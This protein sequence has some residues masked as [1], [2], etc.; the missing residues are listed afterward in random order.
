MP[1]IDI[2]NEPCNDGVAIVIFGVTGDLARR[3][4]MPS[5]YENARNGRLPSPFYIL[6][7]ARRPW[8]HEKMRDVLREGVME[9]GRTKPVDEEIL[10]AILE[11][12]YYIEST[13][14]NPE[15]YTKL[16]ESLKRLGVQNTLFY[17]STP[18]GWYSTIVENIGE[19]QLESCTQGWRRI[20]VEKPFGRDLATAHELD[21]KLHS[22]FAEDQ[23][24][25]MDHYLGKETVQN[26][27]A[28]RFGNGIFEP[29]W[30]RKYVDHIQIT[31]AET[32]GVG[33]RAGYYDKSGVIRDVF[34]NHLLQL[35]SLTAM[36]AP[37]VFNAKAVRDEKVKVLKSIEQITGETALENTIRAQYVS[38][39]IDGERV[40]S[41]RDEP[42]VAPDSITETYV[43]AR[44]FINNWRWAGVPFYLRSGKR[45][46]HRVTEIAIQFT[47][48]PLSLFGQ[49]NLA[50]EAPNMLVLRIQPDE[51]ITLFLG[52][53]S[54]GSVMQ[55][56]PVKMRFSYA[57]AF[58][59]EPPEAYERLLLD[60]LLG[61]ATLFTRSDEVEEAWKLTDG[62]IDAWQTE[63][64]KNLPVYEAGTQGP[65]SAEE[66]IKRDGRR[67]REI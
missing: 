52:A 44:L 58:P 50:G 15:G 11:N 34:Q 64:L 20:V 37:A 1:E 18:P 47:Q 4:L 25:R 31:M 21:A 49:R 45:L 57:E 65:H 16:D 56:E 40:P 9:Y 39:T 26:I 59:G 29:L 17:L 41:Y 43:A 42:D 62:I 61:D 63:D 7:F 14:Q 35:L 48:V 55:I 67:W 46:P 3:K 6:G 33:T 12:A 2:H 30:N 19:S 23:I 24:Y 5:L 36:E 54:P 22:V 13:F 51:G 66:F 53:K 27:L 38:G 28:F 10:D 8:S 32:E 60:S